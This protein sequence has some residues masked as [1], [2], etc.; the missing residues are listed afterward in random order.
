MGVSGTATTKTSHSQRVSAAAKAK[1]MTMIICYLCG[2]KY[3]W[4][5]ACV[6]LQLDDDCAH[7]TLMKDA[8]IPQLQ[9]LLLL[10]LLA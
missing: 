8:Q 7:L 9:F 5:D 10:L 3:V 1:L 2:Y 4:M 6:Y